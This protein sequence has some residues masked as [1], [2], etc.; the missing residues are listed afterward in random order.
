MIALIDTIFAPFINWLIQIRES[1]DN[2]IVPLS[3]GLPINNLFAPIAMISPM[4]ALLISQVFLLCFIYIVL[5][6][7]LN[8][9]GM[10]ESFRNVIKWW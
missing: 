6:V 2:A 7:V 8:G 3:Q 9:V 5:Y 1:L 4:W 10:L